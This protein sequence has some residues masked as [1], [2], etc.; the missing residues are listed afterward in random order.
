MP[1]LAA[2]PMHRRAYEKPLGYAGD[3]R[4]ME[5]C[6][7][8]EPLGDGLFGRFLIQ[9]AQ[10]YTLGADGRGAR[11]RRPRG[12]RPRGGVGRETGPFASWRWRPVRR[13]SSVGGSAR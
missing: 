7:A 13:W 2:C 5:L 6:F 4:M 1:L 8:E 3:Y 12:D 10:H 11:T 9:I